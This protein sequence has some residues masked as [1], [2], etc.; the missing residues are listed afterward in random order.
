MTNGCNIVGI[1]FGVQGVGH[2]IPANVIDD[3]SIYFFLFLFSFLKCKFLHAGEIPLYFFILVKNVRMSY[4]APFN[5]VFTLMFVFDWKIH[6]FAICVQGDREK[7]N[8]SLF[9][10]ESTDII[11][12]FYTLSLLPKSNFNVKVKWYSLNM[13]A[14]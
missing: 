6:V 12:S 5:R 11:H 7:L 2:L 4:C 14:E 3:L 9:S 8:G 13:K 1:V 10:R